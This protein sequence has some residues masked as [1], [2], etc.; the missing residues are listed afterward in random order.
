MLGLS[1]PGFR[2]EG[3]SIQG[4]RARA[5]V[6]R[7][8]DASFAHGFFRGW[9]S[10]QLGSFSNITTI[11]ELQW[12]VWAFLVYFSGFLPKKP[13]LKEAKDEER[14]E[15]RPEER[16]KERQKDTRNKER[17][18]GSKRVRKE[19]RPEGRKKGRKTD[20]R[21]QRN[22]ETK[23]GRKEKGRQEER[24][25]GT[26]KETLLGFQTFKTFQL[27]WRTCLENLTDSRLLPQGRN[28]SDPSSFCLR[29]SIL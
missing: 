12:Q 24:K 1:R 8:L 23:E 25:K 18:Q 3:F 15:G 27:V 17:K 21:N 19:R 2:V 5:V 11:K 16:K 29:H 6:S 7:C 20:T 10:L 28:V 26:K 4:F 14:K 13:R 9:P 22:K